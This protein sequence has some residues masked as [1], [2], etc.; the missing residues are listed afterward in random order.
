MANEL[1]SSAGIAVM[2][3]REFFHGSLL[4]ALHHQH[5][6]LEPQSE[7]YLV[8]VLTRFASSDEFHQN[9]A[10]YRTR[11]PLALLLAEALDA[12]DAGAQRDKLRRL[13]DLSL[14]LAGFFTHS[15]AR[16]L[17][18]VD[19][20]IAMGGSAYGSVADSWRASARGNALASLFTELAAKFQRLVDV[21]NEI[22]DMA[23]PAGDQ[24]ILRLYE[25][26]QKTGSER[27]RRLLQERGIVPLAARGT[28]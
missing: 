28:A 25:T 2:N 18:D 9:D 12:G 13:G 7:Q 6:A 14:F 22:A 16:K 20:C 8:A 1:D 24:D 11:R 4:D 5:V 15:F 21:F 23:R 27:A 17:V 26:W 10:G 3:L 19:Y